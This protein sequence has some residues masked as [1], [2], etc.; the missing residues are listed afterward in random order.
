MSALALVRKTV[1]VLVALAAVFTP[2][3]SVV[4]AGP[5]VKSQPGYYRMMLG[6]FEVT[7]LSDGTVDLQ[8]AQI[9]TNTTPPE[10]PGHSPAST[11]RT[12]SRRRST[13]I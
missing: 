7:A 2:T 4:A 13:P 5:A 1:F 11:C 9:L 8:I 6:D 3:G 12:P 10:W